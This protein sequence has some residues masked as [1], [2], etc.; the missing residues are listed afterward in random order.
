MHIHLNE[1]YVPFPQQ[2]LWIIPKMFGCYG[3]LINV[4][5]EG[6]NVGSICLFDWSLSLFWWDGNMKKPLFC[7]WKKKLLA[8]KCNKKLIILVKP[9]KFNLVF[10]NISDRNK[11]K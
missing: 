7:Q 1:H 8:E 11:D 3:P 10:D 4:V 2:L 6:L 9:N 5:L